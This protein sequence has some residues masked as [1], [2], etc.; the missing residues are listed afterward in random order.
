VA[1][2]IVLAMF[3]LGASVG[4]VRLESGPEFFRSK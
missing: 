2:I 1:T 4:G 3:A